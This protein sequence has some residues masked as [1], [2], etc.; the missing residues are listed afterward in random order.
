MKNLMPFDKLGYPGDNNFYTQ[1]DVCSKKIRAKDAIYKQDPRNTLKGL[2]LCKND[3]DQTNPQVFLK[4]K[5]EQSMRTPHLVRIPSDDA[6]TA[7]FISSSSE[8]ETGNVSDPTGRA[9]GGARLLTIVGASSSQVEF[10][11]FGPDETGSSG[12]NGWVIERET[13]VGGGFSTLETT[14]SEERRVGK[15]CTSW[16]RSR[17]SPY[18]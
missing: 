12:I 10:I 3:N 14:R 9:P 11:W 1:C 2:V 18:H 5:A 7:V 6:P 13:P 8:I 17:W 15:E 4:G 16:C